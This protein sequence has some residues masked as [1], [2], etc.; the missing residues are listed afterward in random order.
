MLAIGEAC[1]PGRF[2]EDSDQILKRVEDRR[3]SMSLESY[4]R[5]SDGLYD[6]AFRHRLGAATRRAHGCELVAES[7]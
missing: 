5:S 4:C 2:E 6:S 3:L 7:A 1:V